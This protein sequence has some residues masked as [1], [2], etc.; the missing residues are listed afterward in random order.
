MALG[1]DRL[2]VVVGDVSGKGV[3]AAFYMAEVKGIFQALSRVAASPRDLLLRANQALAESLERKAFISLLYAIFDIPRSSV[4]LAR[5][6]H[7]PM[8]H[9]SGESST[10]VRPTGLGLGLTHEAIFEYST[11][12]TT[13]KLQ[14]GDICIFYTDGLSESRNT[15]GEEFGHDRLVDV[16]LHNRKNPAESIKNS[17]LQEIRNYTGNSSYGD[18]MTLVVVKII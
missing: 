10:M 13:V 6:G 16:A 11:E 3:S 8:I 7:C 5:A 14:K 9:I 12:E 15:E 1:P 2:G 18:D 4:T 17:I